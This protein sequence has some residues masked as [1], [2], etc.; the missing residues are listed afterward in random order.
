MFT[1]IVEEMGTV[2]QIT[3]VSEQAIQLT[4]E[5]E[6]ITGDLQI[7]DSIAINGICLTV[8]D[9]HADAFYVDVMPET[10]KATSLH[11]VA[12]GSRINLERSLPVDGRVGGHFV[13][14]HVDDTGEITARQKQANAIYYDITVPEK[15]LAFVVTKG[16]I[17]V[18]GVSLTIFAI[19]ENTITL[20]LIPH[21]VSATV[22]GEKGVGDHVNLEFDMLAKYVQNMLSQQEFYKERR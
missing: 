15:F 18:D 4:I 7:G 3:N 13:S 1:G 9:F 19:A 8:T 10:I 12:T 22:L 2:K 6:E 5:A 21:T 14:G 16:S 20:S 11:T 17:A